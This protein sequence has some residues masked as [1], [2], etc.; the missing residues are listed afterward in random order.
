MLVLKLSSRRSVLDTAAH[1]QNRPQQAAPPQPQAVPPRPNGFRAPGAQPLHGEHN[2]LV[3]L[4]GRL[5]RNAAQPPLA[6]ARNPPGQ[7]GP[8]TQGWLPGQTPGVVI[9]YNIQYQHGP[10]QQEQTLLA[11]STSTP[12]QPVPPFAGFVGPNEN[13]RPWVL[14]GEQG[15]PRASTSET[16]SGAGQPAHGPSIVKPGSSQEPSSSRS[17]TTRPPFLPSLI[18]LDPEHIP[19]SSTQTNYTSLLSSPPHSL[20]RSTTSPTDTMGVISDSQLAVLDRNTR[21]AIDE[22][23]RI[24]QNISTVTEGLVQDL[25]RVRSALSPPMSFTVPQETSLHGR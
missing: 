10:R 22:R 8:G 11:G 9:Q 21:E 4:L 18:P 5:A 6:F 24:L 1:D 25:V 23:L 12:L 13:W 17:G 2:P 16:S 20:Q 3:G 14:N 15:V 19:S 7:Q